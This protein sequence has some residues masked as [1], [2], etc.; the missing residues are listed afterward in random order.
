M[1]YELEMQT[2]DPSAPS[3]SE[4]LPS[5]KTMDAYSEKGLTAHLW[6]ESRLLFT[7]HDYFEALEDGIAKAKRSVRIES[8]IF[9]LDQVG[10]NL[11]R[12]LERKAREGVKVRVIV[13]A[14]GSPAWTPERMEEI[15]R[16]GM[17]VRVFGRPRDLFQAGMDLVARGEFRRAFAILRKIQLR[18]HRKLVVIDDELAFVGSS[19]IGAH[20]ANWRETT[21]ALRGPGVARLRA[22][23]VRSWGFSVR[24][25]IPRGSNR[26]PPPG[27]RNNFTSS[28]RRSVNHRLVTRIRETKTKLWITTAYFHPRPKLLLALL[29]ALRR[30]VDVTILV[31]RRSDVRFFPWLSRA[32]F[33][34]LIDAGAKIYEYEGTMMHAKTTVFDDS[35]L[36]GSTNLNY[37]SFM[38]DLELDILVDRSDCV[39]ALEER[40][41]VDLAHS[42]QITRRDA[43][44]YS[45]GARF[46]SALLIPFKRWL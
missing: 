40:F 18:N 15:V 28:E 1:G 29:A 7:G 26:A 9:E 11:L 5:D 45:L 25:K 34:G 19:N 41:R 20:F 14:I 39:A 36:V 8:Y 4:A 23:F 16:S 33:V 43:R 12:L 30:K 2:V 22:S 3:F 35:A 6:S 17:R 27:I 24:E 31:P 42:V 32:F 21:V 13:D 10:L 37:R 38:H 44:G 46:V